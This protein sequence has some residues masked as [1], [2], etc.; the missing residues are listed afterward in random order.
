MAS[1]IILKDNKETAHY[2]VEILGSTTQ[3]RH[4][5]GDS[6][7]KIDTNPR[8]CRVSIGNGEK[9]SNASLKIHDRKGSTNLSSKHISTKFVSAEKVA[10]DQLGVGELTIARKKGRDL[11]SGK[12]HVMG[13]NGEPVV[14][15]D[16]ENGDILIKGIDGSLVDKLKELERGR[17]NTGSHDSSGAYKHQQV[18]HQKTP[19]F[20][21]YETGTSNPERSIISHSEKYE[22]WGLSY[23][24]K[25]D[26]MIFQ[27]GG[28]SVLTV[29]LGK[30]KVGVGTDTPSHAL[31]VDGEVAGRGGFKSL[32]DIRCKQNVESLSDSLA[33]IMNLRGVSFNWN[34][35]E[36]TG[37]N[38]PENL[39]LGFIAQ[40]VKKVL[41]DIV[42]EDNLGRLSLSYS[43]LIPLLVESIQQQQ[44][45]I[46]EHKKR[47]EQMGMKNNQLRKRVSQI[48]NVVAS[49]ADKSNK[50]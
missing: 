25:G 12:L 6:R 2:S 31:H 23:R 4:P 24:D 9:T 19:Q 14:T 44:R 50:V 32:S 43:S 7:L 37:A 48:E 18:K 47:L 38:P 46:N 5:N 1:D 27:A 35:D 11:T 21:I 49:L 16:G 40:E 30:K 39:E 17:E 34:N 20:Y 8:M 3:I 45:T 28:S 36:L 15:I 29:A 13:F 22:N 10:A 42:S 33:K 41:P 26:Q